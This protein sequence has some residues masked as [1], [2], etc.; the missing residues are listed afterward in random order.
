MSTFRCPDCKGKIGPKNFDEEFAMYECPKCEGLF[1]LEELAPKAV[2]PNHP[3]DD[4]E[5]WAEIIIGRS[6]KASKAVPA[7]K[8]KKRQAEREADEELAQEQ[9]EAITKTVKKTEKISRHR[10]EMETGLVL[11][12]VADE[13]ELLAEEM[14]ISMNRTNAREYYAMNLVR[15]LILKGHYPREQEIAIDYCKEHR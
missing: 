15:P 6:E 8:G 2:K 13:M 3:V 14:G 12:V 9:I 1:T 10:D 11:N 4:D 7:A 5:R